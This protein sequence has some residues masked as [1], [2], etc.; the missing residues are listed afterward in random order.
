[1]RSAIKSKVALDDNPKFEQEFR[2]NL[3]TQMQVAP[4]LRK[5]KYAW[6]SFTITIST[7]KSMRLMSSMERVFESLFPCDKL[8]KKALLKQSA[9]FPVI[10]S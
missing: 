4:S 3:K 2:N 9:K 1:M 7:I 6:R 5:F 8:F 10:D